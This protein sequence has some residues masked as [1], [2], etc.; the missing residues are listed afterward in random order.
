MTDSANAVPATK[1]WTSDTHRISEM[2]ELADAN[3]HSRTEGAK[4]WKSLRRNVIIQL[5]STF[6]MF[7]SLVDYTLMLLLVTP[8]LTS[9]TE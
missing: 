7:D 5:Q 1:A 3:L 8:S 4:H 9:L 2:S 6:N